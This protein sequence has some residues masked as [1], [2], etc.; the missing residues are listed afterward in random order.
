MSLPNAAL[1]FVERDIQRP[2]QLVLDTPVFPDGHGEPLHVGRQAANKV[3]HL[4]GLLAVH[5][6]LATDTHDALGVGPVTGDGLW[7]RHGGVAA[8]LRSPM[9]LLTSL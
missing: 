7:C 2:M 9:L 3:T 8:L 6:G 4:F 5:C 1:V